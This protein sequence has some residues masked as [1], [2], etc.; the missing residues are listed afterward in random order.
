ML[1]GSSGARVGLK[2]CPIA[3]DVTPEV[4]EH[5]VPENNRHFRRG[6]FTVVLQLMRGSLIDDP[7]ATIRLLPNHPVMKYRS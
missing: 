4:E 5:Y 1:S 3:V 7:V 2:G 6:V